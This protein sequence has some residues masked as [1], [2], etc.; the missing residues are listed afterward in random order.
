MKQLTKVI[1]S[2][3]VIL[4]GFA[5][6]VP[7]AEK[8]FIDWGRDSLLVQFDGVHSKEYSIKAILDNAQSLARSQGVELVLE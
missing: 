6:R 5:K 1:F 2:K 7:N 8:M 4:E 3:S